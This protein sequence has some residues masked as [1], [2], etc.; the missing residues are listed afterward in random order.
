M[1]HQKTFR[2]RLCVMKGDL[3]QLQADQMIEAVFEIA[4]E[5]VAALTGEQAQDIPVVLLQVLQQMWKNI[6]GMTAQTE[7]AASCGKGDR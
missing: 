7:G 6:A 1:I 2:Q 4:E 3:L 5:E